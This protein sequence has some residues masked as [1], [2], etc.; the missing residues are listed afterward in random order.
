M[1]LN[2]KCSDLLI[3]NVLLEILNSNEKELFKSNTTQISYNKGNSIV[4]QGE[5]VTEAIFICQGFV[6]VHSDFRNRNV[7]FNVIGPNNFAGLGSMVS[8]E[9]HP[10]NITAIDEVNACLIDIKTVRQ[11]AYSNYQFSH[12]I[13]QLLNSSVLHYVEHTLV[14]LTQ[15]NIHGRIANTI[16]YLSEQVFKNITFDMLL[17]RKELAQFCNIS[18]E[19]VIKVLY[20]FNNDGLIR[21]NGKKIQILDIDKLRRIANHG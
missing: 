4:K 14:S 20:E 18:R 5:F 13:L 10:F 21:L 3:T 16:I 2:M 6:K 11:I 8:M 7:V 1:G 15:N 12:S 19:N 9:K 17:S